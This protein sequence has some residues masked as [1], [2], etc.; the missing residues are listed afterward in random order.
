[1]DL[2]VGNRES[3]RGSKSMKST[4]VLASA[5]LTAPPPDRHCCCPAC[6]HRAVADALLLIRTGRALPARRVLEALE[7]DLSE[8]ALL[9]W[10]WVTILA[11]GPD[12]KPRSGGKKQEAGA[13]RGTDLFS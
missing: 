10:L 6:A 2:N 11:D 3:A 5:G 1:M 4:C 9:T 7:K 13:P 8:A 12:R